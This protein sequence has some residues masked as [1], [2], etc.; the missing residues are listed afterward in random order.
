MIDEDQDNQTIERISP[1]DNFEDKSF[2]PSSNKINNNFPLDFFKENKENY[3]FNKQYEITDNSQS[4]INPLNKSRNNLNTSSNINI[5]DIFTAVEYNDLERANELLRQDPSQ[6][7]KLN[8]EGLSLLHIAVIKANLKMIDL[9]LSF[10]ADAN[11]LTNKK[12]QTPLHLA[13]L[14]QN[15]LT[16]DIVQ[17]LL[18]NDAHDTILDFNSKKPSDYMCST[19]KKKKN[20]NSNNESDKKS[21]V[22]NN[23]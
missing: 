11:I 5:G 10:G 23:T 7:N 4:A 13:Y 12:K 18:K 19:Y 14:N 3:D 20:Y 8:E 17:E 1:R 6:I 16:E 2:S 22:N 15:S 9:L 21:Y